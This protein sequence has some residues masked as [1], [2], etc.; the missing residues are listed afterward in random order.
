MEDVKAFLSDGD[1]SGYGDGH[2]SGHGSGDGSGYG[3]GYGDGYGS[4]YG[5][6]YGDG[7]GLKSFNG[8]EAYLV[9]GIE[10]LIDHVHGDFAKGAILNSDL[11]LTLCYIARQEGKYAHG[12]T[13]REARAAVLEKIFDD[14]PEE[15]RI[16]AFVE[17]H[18]P[19]VVYSDADFFDWHHKLTGSCEMGR[20]AFAKARGLDDLTGSRT[21]REFI[22]LCE[23]DYGGEIIKQ[24]K[25]YY[26]V[27]E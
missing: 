8:R 14:I 6:G 25:P 21:V 26:E 12:K 7:Y 24:L 13:L 11:T 18:K 20:M 1:G 10:T 15:E 17:A 5:D 19:G 9:D 16:A 27:S 4:G 2:G 22:A 3:D 23:N